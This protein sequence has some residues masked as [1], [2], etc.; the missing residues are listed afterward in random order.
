MKN[1][2]TRYTP[3]MKAKIALAAL[4]EEEPMAVLA[5]RVGV[6][7]NQISKWQRELL[8]NAARAFEPCGSANRGSS[9]R[10]DELLEKI[11]ELT[12]ERDFYR[13]GSDGPGE[14]ASSDGRGGGVCL[15]A[16]TVRDAS[17]LALERLLLRTARRSS[18]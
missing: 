4:R 10:E 17:R 12:V 7:P 1:T 3:E 11:A 6:H 5:K 18:G 8:E 16:A 13:A 2:R 15:D 9:K 14:G